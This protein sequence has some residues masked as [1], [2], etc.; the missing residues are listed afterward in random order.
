MEQ[1]PYVVA[2]V[3]GWVAPPIWQFVIK[4]VKGRFFR[5]MTAILLSAVT[6]VAA[7]L[8]TN[9]PFSLTPEMVS[10]VYLFSQA[11]FLGYWKKHFE[12]T[13]TK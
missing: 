6:A 1:L 13:D 2:T 3:L 8:A 12:E 7:M 9:T 11:A 4:Y 5:F 10:I